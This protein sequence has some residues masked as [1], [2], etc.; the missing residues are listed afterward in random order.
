MVTQPPPGLMSPLLCPSVCNTK[1]LIFNIG[2]K[3]SISTWSHLS[4]VPPLQIPIPTSHLVLYSK[5]ASSTKNYSLLQ[6]TFLRQ[7]KKVLP[8]H[9]TSQKC[10]ATHP[11]VCRSQIRNSNFF[12]ATNLLITTFPWPTYTLQ[13][14]VDELNKSKSTGLAHVFIL[15]LGLVRWWW[16]C[17]CLFLWQWTTVSAAMVVAV[18]ARW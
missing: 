2:I 4:V 11:V 16:C 15:V 13:N 17:C 18:M 5:F 3:I 9:T 7:R 10:R 12:Q 8:A 6:Q 14:T 1:K